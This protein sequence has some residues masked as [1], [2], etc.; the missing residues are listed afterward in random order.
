MD[1]EFLERIEN[2]RSRTLE[3]LFESAVENVEK[4]LRE[5]G[6]TD[7]DEWALK[8]IAYT[9]YY[10]WESDDPN[11]VFLLEDPGN[12]NGRHTREIQRIE[13][14]KDDYDPLSL[15]GI[16]RQFATTWFTE[17]R[18]SDFIRR[19]LYTCSEN[20]LIEFDDYWGDYV[21]SQRF[22]DDFYTT[23]IVKYRAPGSAVGSQEV[24]SSFSERLRPE[25]ETST[26]TSS[27]RSGTVPGIPSRRNLP[28]NPSRTWLSTSRK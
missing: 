7:L 18:N 22:F 6:A 12:L 10:D 13:N 19:F 11:Y 14:L 24:R 16:Y 9:Y 25:L 2:P 28:L 3:Q 26:P 4:Q 21:K 8:K 5:Y 17:T 15:V 1:A 20:D 23:D 27:S